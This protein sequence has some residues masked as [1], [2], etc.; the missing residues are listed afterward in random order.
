MDKVIPLAPHLPNFNVKPFHVQDNGKDIVRIFVVQTFEFL[1]VGGFGLVLKLPF[2]V[3]V[4][5]VDGCCFGP[6]RE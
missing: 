2:F 6:E 3:A 5:G 4:D 1:V